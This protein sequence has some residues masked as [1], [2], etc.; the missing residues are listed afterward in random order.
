M[1]VAAEKW[2]AKWCGALSGELRYICEAI[3]KRSDIATRSL[4]DQ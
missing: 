4:S 3:T 1:W 2:G